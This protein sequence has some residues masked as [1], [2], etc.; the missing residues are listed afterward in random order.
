MQVPRHLVAVIDGVIHDVGD[1]GGAGRR[2]VQGYWM[3][4]EQDAA[5]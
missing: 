2:R 4:A 5:R 1:C 3:M